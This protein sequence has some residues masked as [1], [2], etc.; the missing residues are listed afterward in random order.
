MREGVLKGLW[1]AV[2]VGVGADGGQ[3]RSWTV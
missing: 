2:R 3:E 1:A